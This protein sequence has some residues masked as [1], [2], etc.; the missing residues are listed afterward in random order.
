MVSRPAEA[1][2]MKTAKSVQRIVSIY[3]TTLTEVSRVSSQLQ[4][5]CEG[6][7][8]K[9]HVPP[10]PV[11]EAFSQNDFPPKSPRPSA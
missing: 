10:S 2:R 9:G 6:F 7:I 8:Q 1:L 5:K 4:G 3:S 11:M